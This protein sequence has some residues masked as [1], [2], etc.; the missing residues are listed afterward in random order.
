MN[1]QIHHP[2]LLMLLLL[3]IGGLTAAGVLLA[4]G[5]EEAVT[6]TPTGDGEFD[7]SRIVIPQRL[8]PIPSSPLPTPAPPDDE[9][10]KQAKK[11]LDDS[12]MVDAIAGDQ[13]WSIAWTWWGKVDGAD[14]GQAISLGVEWKKPVKSSGPWISL[15]CQGTWIGKGTDPWGN[16]HVLKATINLKTREVVQ[17]V[18]SSP[19]TLDSEESKS[20]EPVPLE[21][22]E[23]HEKTELYEAA[24]GTLLF[25]GWDRDAP[26]K[27]RQCPP[28]KGDD[29]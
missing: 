2:R 13:E 10:V 29:S 17:F 6:P 23:E 4:E 5:G 26:A 20:L 12:G 1:L 8:I 11:I 15:Y 24:T 27:Y 21:R 14:E 3:L 9:K 22:K 16:I 18:V 19:R 25:S 7:A 28:G